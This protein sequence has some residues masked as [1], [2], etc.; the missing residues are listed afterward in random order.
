MGLESDLKISKKR[1]KQKRCMKCCGGLISKPLSLTYKIIRYS[2]MKGIGDLVAIVAITLLFATLYRV[3]P[4]IRDTFN[5]YRFKKK[6]QKQIKDQSDEYEHEYV[7]G[8]SMRFGFK[9]IVSKHCA[10]FWNDT[11][12]F[13]ELLCWSFLILI[14]LVRL[15]DYM[16]RLMSD[17]TKRGK[18]SL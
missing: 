16:E 17:A 1:R 14:S 10:A 9:R 3:V 8:P 12:R 18:R 15:F 13:L 5:M 6:Y 7:V 2:F 11:S 4:L